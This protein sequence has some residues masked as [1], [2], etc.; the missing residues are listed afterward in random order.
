M[1]SLISL[2]LELRENIYEYVLTA[3][4]ATAPPDVDIAD[5]LLV[6]RETFIGLTWETE[7]RYIKYI[8]P[9]PPA[10]AALLLLNRQIH[11]EV[12]SVLRRMAGKI[13]Y[14]ID[15]IVADQAELLPTWISIPALSSRVRS[16]KAT[17]RIAGDFH[18]KKSRVRKFN[19]GFVGTPPYINW[20]FYNVLHRFLFLGPVGR[21]SG[22]GQ[23]YYN[24]RGQDIRKDRQVILDHL[25][26]EVLTPTHI[27]PKR[28]RP[29]SY[30]RFYQQSEPGMEKPKR[31]YVLSPDYLTNFICDRIG[32]LLGMS[33]HALGYGDILYERIGSI[34]ILQ[35][36]VEKRY[37]DLGD[38]LPQLTFDKPGSSREPLFADFMNKIPIVRR[39]NGLSVTSSLATGKESVAASG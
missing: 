29:A 33:Y 23:D 21:Y 27:D 20:E 39:N 36:G 11:N 28:L 13:D 25:E 7:V 34:R 30:R 4:I 14:D 10:C 32:F 22:P 18:L 5:E 37:W 17:F 16:V 35:D 1:A 24:G 2:P 26:I 19:R 9:P 8:N 3:P 12:K 31:N 38:C 6:G 15:I